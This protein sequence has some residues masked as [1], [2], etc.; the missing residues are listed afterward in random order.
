M[1]PRITIFLAGIFGFLGVAFGAFGAHG[2]KG[3]VSADMLANWNTAA[4][5]QMIHALALLTAGVLQ[6]LQP[7]R[8]SLSAAAVLFVTGTLIFSGSLYTLVLTDVRWLGA[9][10]PIG[11]TALLAGWIAFAIAGLALKSSRV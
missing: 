5:Y 7:G 11:G 8:R 2:L 3:R 10:T 4:H 9:I 6:L 1:T